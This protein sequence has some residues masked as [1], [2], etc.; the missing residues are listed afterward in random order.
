MAKFFSVEELNEMRSSMSSS[1]RASYEAAKQSGDFSS[2]SNI[3]ANA[4]NRGTST[5]KQQGTN[6]VP[7][8]GQQRLNPDSS[9]FASAAKDLIN[10]QE[11]QIESRQISDTSAHAQ[12]QKDSYVTK[13]SLLDQYHEQANNSYDIMRAQDNARGQQLEREYRAAVKAYEDANRKA[14]SATMPI[15]TG[16]DLLFDTANRGKIQQNSVQDAAIEARKAVDAAKEKLDAWNEQHGGNK[17]EDLTTFSGKVKDLFYAPGVWDNAGLSKQQADRQEELKKKLDYGGLS[18]AEKKDVLQELHAMDS[19]TGRE[20]RAYTGGERARNFFD[21]WMQGFRGAY[22]NAAGNVIELN[23]NTGA[24]ADI[25]RQ[26]MEQELAAATRQRQRA[27]TDLENA[28]LLAT[29]GDKEAVAK[30]TEK[31]NNLDNYINYLNNELG[32]VGQKIAEQTDEQIVNPLYNYADREL[33]ASGAKMDAVKYGKS[34]AFGFAAD[35]AKTGL[36]MAADAALN[37]PVSGAGLASMAARVY[38]Q[39][40][41]EA[42]NEGD[43]AEKAAAKGL[44]SALIEIATEKLG[45]TN[46]SYGEG[47]ISKAFKN[48]GDKLASSTAWRV[49]SDTLGEGLEEV[50]SD[51]LNTAAEHGFGWDD[52]TRTLGEALKDESGQMLYDFMLGSAV[53]ALGTGANAVT[54]AYRRGGGTPAQGGVVAE[55]TTTADNVEAI[56]QSTQ[57]AAISETETVPQTA[58]NAAEAT[59]GEAQVN[60]PPI[61]QNAVQPQNQPA[62]G[63]MQPQTQE[64]PQT[65]NEAMSIEERENALG[66]RLERFMQRQEEYGQNE[67]MFAELEAEANAID[68]GEKAIK[69]LRAQQE[70]VNAGEVS[71]GYNQPENHIDNRS[72]GDV[73]KQSTKAFQFDHPELHPYFVEAAQQL[74]TDVN[75]M[76]DTDA[77]LL[78]GRGKMSKGAR[79]Y[80]ATVK[81]LTDAGMTKPRIMQTLQDIIDNNGA[82][83][84]ADAKRTEIV[85]N[86]MLSNG[87][88]SADRTAHPANSA[89]VA[90]KNKINGAVNTDAWSAYKAEHELELAT[91][92]VTEEQLRAEF[93]AANERKNAPSTSRP[94]LPQT[95]G[96][97]TGVEETNPAASNVPT[98][99]EDIF[100]DTR[101]TRTGEN[102]NGNFTEAQSNVRERGFSQ[103]IR[104]DAAM[105]QDIRQSFETSPETYTQLSNK[106]TIAKAQEIFSR[107]LDEAQSTVEQALGAAKE[108][109]K[110][111]PEMVP[112]SRMVANELS[113]QGNTDAARRILSDLSFELTAAGQFNQAAKLLRNS[114]PQTALRAIEKTLDAVNTEYEKAHKKSD[115]RAELTE[116]EREEILSTDFTNEDNYKDLYE[117]VTERIGKEMPSDV[118]EKLTELRRINML[119]RPRTMIKNVVSNV[120]MVGLRKGA[121]TLSIGIQK[122]LSATGFMDEAERTRG[123]ASKEQRQLARNYYEANKADI[124]GQS[125]KWDFRSML[126]ENRTIFKGG[127]VE[128]ALSKMTGKE[129]ESF[130]EA[131]RHVTYDLLEKGDAPFV[132]SAFVDSL[133]QYCAAK[134]ITSAEGITPAAV[135]FATANAMEATFKNANVIADLVNQ[136]KRNSSPAVAAAIDVIIP[137]TTTPANILSLMGDYSP[138]G[139]GKMLAKDGIAAKIDAFS[140]ATVGSALMALGWALRGAGVITGGEDDDKDKAAYDKANGIGTYSIGGKVSYDWAQPMGSLLAFGAEIADATKGQESWSSALL[141]AVY[142]AGDS[143]LNLSLFQNIMSILK[144]KGSSATQ[145]LIDAVIEGSATQLVPGLAGDIAKLIDSTVRSTYT[146]GNTL[147]DSLAKVTAMIPGLSK[148]LPESVN[149]KGETNTRGSWYENFFNTLVNPTNVARGTKDAVDEEVYRL[150]DATGGKSFIPSVSPYKV[151]YENKE[152]TMNGKERETFQKVQGQTYYELAEPLLS[153]EMYKALSDDQKAAVLTSIRDYALD[154]AKRQFVDRKNDAGEYTSAWD[155]MQDLPDKFNYL[156]AN[157]A[158]SSAKKSG[159]AKESYSALDTAL[160]YWDELSAKSRET[161]L[162]KSDLHTSSLVYANKLGQNAEMWYS[163]KNA[164]DADAAKLGG[165][166]AAKAISVYNNMK[167]KNNDEILTAMKAQLVP[168]RGGKTNTTIRKVEAYMTAAEKNGYEANLGEWLNLVANVADA[169][170]NG[171]S[172]NYANVADG[173]AA[174]GLSDKDTYAGIDLKTAY[175][176]LKTGTKS[177]AL[178][179]EYAA[180]S[181]SIFAGILPEVEKTK[182]KLGG[183]VAGAQKSDPDTQ[184]AYRMLGLTS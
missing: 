121:E 157:Q 88:T 39:T 71:R 125:N 73:A 86:D 92:E 31:L 6:R 8:A 5:S 1:E 67:A 22:A 12:A 95:N 152:Y 91:G 137:F 132:K 112:L 90:A 27:E 167:G 108:G 134:G 97:I 123:W 135:E 49:V 51:V 11:K 179:P 77:A 150:V 128:K 72:F 52:G 104:T 38:G 172:P 56:P 17:A 142:T 173:W 34:K 151:E 159:A 19:A 161:L 50:V 33:A 120:P 146:G 176:I 75:T 171:G 170:E 160:K 13:N 115:W 84:Y 37:I 29:L 133:S 94:G 81:R 143:A 76:I 4:V 166:D 28:K 66:E 53:G 18:S 156:A 110:L 127:A 80:G 168:E 3:F 109:R 89:Y 2:A 16:A 130:G 116:A 129:V 147:D 46:L 118:F 175:N 153:S 113:R 177:Y 106:E 62:Q 96:G 70:R 139:F 68:A 101:I 64:A 145:Q 48:A 85:L 20:T 83:N 55:N 103:N 184:K 45:G 114:D 61:A 43:S 54:G 119:L 36:D 165:S 25:V 44:T 26:T 181:D 155:K 164:I 149:V 131:L 141:N 180:Q 158:F 162:G 40:A 7:V 58:Q 24:G 102:V 105:E 140:K 111:A 138:I 69:A 100:S 47:A 41:A 154:E 79:Q 98:V 42:R 23:K 60:T 182:A 32:K 107:G 57:A 35:M 10:K 122:A 174:L 74:M 93:E 99:S 126:K 14:G 183:S 65:S 78:S 82:E 136:A 148:K 178:N 163:N 9:A 124:N 30:A 21:S 59:Q 169:D 87:W 63:N 117:R 144:G 15:M